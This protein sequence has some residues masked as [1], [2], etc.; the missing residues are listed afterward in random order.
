[1]EIEMRT[2]FED[3]GITVLQEGDKF[4][5]RYDSGEIVSKI[6]MIEVS[7]E[8]A[9]AAQRGE[10]DAYHVIIRNIKA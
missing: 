6:D 1:M 8:D 3:Y 4:F 7:K 2:I 5:I 9:I 10:E